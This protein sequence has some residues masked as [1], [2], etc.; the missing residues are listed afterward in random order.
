M[1]R[2]DNGS[3]DDKSD[4]KV[5]VSS[6]LRRSRAQRNQGRYGDS[7]DESDGEEPDQD[8]KS[9]FNETSKAEIG[10][11]KFDLSQLDETIETDQD[12]N[13]LIDGVKKM[14]P[15]QRTWESLVKF[16]A[17]ASILAIMRTF[18]CTTQYAKRT[19]D[20][21]GVNLFQ[22]LKARNPALNVR[23]RH[24]PV[25]TDT[26][27][28]ST[29]AIA[30]GSECAQFYVGR[31]S[32][33]KS[34]Y[35][36]KTDKQFTKT[37]QDEI[38]KNGAMDILYSDGASAQVGQKAK[39][40]M[41]SFVID[42]WASKPHNPNQNFAERAWR[43]TK[44]NVNATMNMTGAPANTW[45]LA[46]KYVIYVMNQTAIASLNWRTPYEKM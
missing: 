43:D 24:E 8:E 11:G 38:R 1:N 25:A 12:G 46:L 28:S 34:A 36:C 2:Q 33:Y 35:G 42:D 40:I 39:E 16:F 44:R 10:D 14:K 3:S 27:Y 21:M 20:T 45:L 17:G 6:S 37:L 30:D 41:R 26:V 5:S 32:I 29:K 15:T 31:D 13:E 9:V 4:D 7:D 19:H 18:S 23:R 22:N